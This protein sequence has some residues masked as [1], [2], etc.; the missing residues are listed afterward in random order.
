MGKFGNV[1]RR[2]VVGGRRVLVGLQEGLSV[3]P[4]ARSWRCYQGLAARSYSEAVA[5]GLAFGYALVNRAA[6]ELSKR[7]GGINLGRVPV[8]VGL[9]SLRRTLG[10]RGWPRALRLAAMAAQPL[11]GLR[12]GR[13]FARDVQLRAIER[14][15]GA[16]DDLWQALAPGRTVT[17]VRDADYMNW[18]YVDRPGCRYCRLGAYRGER[19]DGVIVFRMK[20]PP[21]TAVILELLARGDEH[22]VLAALLNQAIEV[23]SGEGAGLIAGSFPGG[24]AETAAL[25]RRGFHPWA[26]RVWGI[27]L[28]LSR[29][30]DT[31]PAAE[32][33]MANWRFSLGDW[34]VH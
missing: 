9:P 14:F 7:T 28:V 31:P 16:C 17:A 11:V 5:D 12:R 29:A 10:G 13:R 1:H 3:L 2:F 15:D 24:S 19:L 4:A 27:D 25:K 26:T 23:L 18:R 22:A 8:W 20:S 33:D 32:T 21:A 30:P 34:L 6:T